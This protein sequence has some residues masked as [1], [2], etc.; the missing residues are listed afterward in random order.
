[1]HDEGY[2]ERES[3]M[4]PEEI[5]AEIDRV[6]NLLLGLEVYLE[7]TNR[8]ELATLIGEEC[9]KEYVT[10]KS[11]RIGPQAIDTLNKIKDFFRDIKAQVLAS[12]VSE[13]DV[14][15]TDLLGYVKM[16]RAESDVFI[17][18]VRKELVKGA[19]PGE[20]VDRLE[21]ELSGID[22]DQDIDPKKI[23]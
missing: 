15:D 2:K 8:P 7:S 19:Y 21:D 18:R 23:N 16:E 20:V 3:N 1:M 12:G 14:A 5:E 6:D 11:H 10:Q 13:S 17:D 22:D 9:K 4:S